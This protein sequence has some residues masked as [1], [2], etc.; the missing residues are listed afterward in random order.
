MQDEE[1]IYKLVGVNIHVGTA[2]HGH[3]YSLINT[4]RGQEEPDESKPEWGQPEKDQWRE[5][6]DESIKY[7][8]FSDLK[9]EA[10]GGSSGANNLADNEMTAYLVH[11][12]AAQSYGKNAYMLIYERQLKKD[13]KVVEFENPIPS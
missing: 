9:E 1:F 12:G 4:K 7:F 8:T 11:S 6:N 5:F 2:E 10:F 3:Y 13:L